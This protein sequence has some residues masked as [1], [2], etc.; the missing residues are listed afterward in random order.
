MTGENKSLNIFKAFSVINWTGNM[1]LL[2]LT[3]TLFSESWSWQRSFLF[4]WIGTE[5]QM[6]YCLLLVG[7]FHCICY[8]FGFRMVL[9]WLLQILMHHYFLLF[10]FFSFLPP[11]Y[12][13]LYENQKTNIFSHTSVL[14]FFG[15]L[16]LRP[17]EQFP[18][19]P[20]GVRTE[21][22]IH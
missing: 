22:N 4:Q 3:V 19:Y 12:F 11:Y 10:N 16:E 2:G 8:I 15:L 14:C 7:V 9:V 1:L 21:R 5:A 17:H 18:C 20:M 13:F 6:Q